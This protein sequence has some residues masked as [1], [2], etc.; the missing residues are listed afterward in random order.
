LAIAI[1]VVGNHF[2]GQFPIYRSEFW[3]SFDESDVAT[4]FFLAFGIGMISMLVW[5]WIQA[6]MRGFKSQQNE[7]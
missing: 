5:G 7:D 4:T 3:L 1:A 6:R 2:L